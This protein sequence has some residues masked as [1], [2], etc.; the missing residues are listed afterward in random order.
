MSA[1]GV[2]CTFDKDGRV[3]VQRVQLK[4][5]W[6]PVSQGRQWSEEDGRHV[7][8]MFPGNKIEELILSAED[9]VWRLAS[10]RRWEAA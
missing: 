4:G 7:L 3:R 9:L 8:V 1:V 10:R 2:E 5:A 6:I